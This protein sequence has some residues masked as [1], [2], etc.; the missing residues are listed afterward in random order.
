MGALQKSLSTSETPS[1][2]S[3]PR[4]RARNTFGVDR[5]L[6]P[7]RSLRKVCVSSEKRPPVSPATTTSL[8]RPLPSHELWISVFLAPTGEGQSST[9]HI[10][11]R[12]CDSP[13]ARSGE[14]EG[15][16]DRQLSPVKDREPFGNRLVGPLRQWEGRGYART[17][18]LTLWRQPL[19]RCVPPQTPMRS[20][21][22]PEPLPS[23]NWHGDGQGSREDGHTGRS[24]RTV[25]EE[26]G[27][28][29]TAGAGRK[30]ARQMAT[31]RAEQGP[32][33]RRG[34]RDHHSVREAL[35]KN[36]RSVMLPP[37]LR[38]AN[39]PGP[40]LPEHEAE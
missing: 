29:Q 18:W 36:Q 12:L 32:L 31:L 5:V 10:R 24:E 38:N 20:R 39:K 28:I 37:I 6:A 1:A 15:G 35:L 21:A 11:Q 7:A 16:V 3:V 26:G 27:G 17:H 9:V 30:E 23:N 4:A 8:A 19:D 22:S 25:G 13:S 14:T 2:S 33:G 40:R 34:T